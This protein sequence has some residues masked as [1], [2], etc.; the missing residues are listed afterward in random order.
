M[1]TE[2]DYNFVC[3]ECGESLMVN[4]PMKDALIDKG[5]VVCGSDVSGNAFSCC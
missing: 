1:S 3:P 2:E 4:G 5:C